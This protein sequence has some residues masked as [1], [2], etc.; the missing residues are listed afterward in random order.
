[1]KIFVAITPYQ[2]K[3]FDVYKLYTI[4]HYSHLCTQID[5]SVGTALLPLRRKGD[6]EKRQGRTG[7][8][9]KTGVFW[10]RD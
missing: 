3:L 9:V 4:N 8:K 7:R 5:T 2:C 6:F 10:G 1:M